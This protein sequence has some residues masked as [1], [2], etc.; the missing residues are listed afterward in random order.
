MTNDIPASTQIHKLRAREDM[1]AAIMA[2]NTEA[3]A[4]ILDAHPEFAKTSY[5]IGFAASSGIPETIALLI[6]KGVSP[7][8]ETSSGEHPLHLAV[9]AAKP[10]N[11]RTLINHGAYINITAGDDRGWTP[12]HYAVT[13]GNIEAI[14]ILLEKNA[15]PARSGKNEGDTPLALAESYPKMYNL[16]EAA[17]KAQINEAVHQSWLREQQRL[18]SRYKPSS[19]K[20]PPKNGNGPG[21]SK[22]PPVPAFR[23]NGPFV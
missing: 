11:I 8:A 22:E 7:D 3:V 1:L 23:P 10:A 19:L 14:N 21:Q 5:M 18:Q 9:K 12:L 16:L 15:D 6:E 20:F 17:R 2:G 13:S 4:R